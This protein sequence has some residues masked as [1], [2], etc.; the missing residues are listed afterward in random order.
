M[1]K[2]YRVL[3]MHLQ[4]K[5]LLV[6]LLIT[7]CC[8]AQAQ[9][10][11]SDGKGGTD[12]KDY[13]K[14]MEQDESKSMRVAGQ[15]DLGWL[16][17]WG[18]DEKPEP[19]EEPVPAPSAPAESAQ[20]PPK[21]MSVEWFAKNYQVIRDRAVN[22]PTRENLRAELYAQKVMMDKSEV[23]AR[24]RQY[25]Q[26]S[27]P[28]LQEGDRLPLF[29][30]TSLAMIQNQDIL[31]E[32]AL[33]ELYNES[34]LMV[35]Y[36]ENCQFCRQSITVVNYLHRKF[37]KL[38]IRVYARNTA[39][40]DVVQG[41][42]QDI[43]V[44]PDDLINVSER[45]EITN[46]PSYVLVTP[47]NTFSLISKGMIN[48]DTLKDRTLIA[49]FEHGI[50]GKEWYEK[51]HHTQMGLIASNEYSDLPSGME[52]DPVL[53][54]NSVIDMINDSSNKSFYEDFYPENKQAGESK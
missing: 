41:L 24:K 42:L 8:I 39:Q 21:P 4:L 22:N 51:I 38:D 47:D 49:G 6:C 30:A 15:E 48:L 19:E 52:E 50:L 36:D 32:K 40:P 20:K 10:S 2:R 53:L 14:E 9:T 31:K 3:V 7:Q 12:K 18:D 43:K 16:F 23:Y 33:G 54:I 17:Y 44:Y 29:G 45:L 13:L 46:W 11:K 5:S 26:K 37:P 25:M 34:G 28:L 27:D 35:F 1:K